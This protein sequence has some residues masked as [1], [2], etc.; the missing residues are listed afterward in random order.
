MNAES[1]TPIER[2][3]CDECG[4]GT[5]LRKAPNDGNEPE[6]TYLKAGFFQEGGDSWPDDG[7]LDEGSCMKGQMGQGMWNADC[8]EYNTENWG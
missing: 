4:Y 8:C 3:W 2:A 6:Q 5:W 1:G 7:K